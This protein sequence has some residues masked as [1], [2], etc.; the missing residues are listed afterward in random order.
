MNTTISQKNFDNAQEFLN[1]VDKKLKGDVDFLDHVLRTTRQ[2]EDALAN[3]RQVATNIFNR[4][5]R[6]G[7]EQETQD[8]VHR[9]RRKCIHPPPSPNPIPKVVCIETPHPP[10]SRI[11]KKTIPKPRIISTI[12]FPKRQDS[13]SNYHTPPQS[14]SGSHHNS[15]IVNDD[16]EIPGDEELKV[17]WSCRD[18]P[19]TPA[20][21]LTKESRR[22]GNRKLKAP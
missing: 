10:D 16:E 9:L 11:A 5:I 22:L 8:L 19:P 7:F 18:R 12:P 6:H 17:Y 2:M 20:F 15:I 21:H 4:L 3:Q 14:P 13:L 1:T